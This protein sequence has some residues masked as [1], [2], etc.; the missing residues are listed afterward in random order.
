M[1]KLSILLTLVMSSILFYSCDKTIKGEGE[2]VQKVKNVDNFTQ[3]ISNIKDP[4]II[5]QGGDFKVILKGQENIIDNIRV[6]A[7]YGKLRIEYKDG[8]Q[9]SDYK[10]VEVMVN[11]PI[12]TN[13]SVENGSMNLLGK[14]QSNKLNFRVNG[15]GVILADEVNVDTLSAEVLSNGQLKI[16]QGNTV[17]ETI[18]TFGN[19]YVDLIGVVADTAIIKLSGSGDIYVNVLEYL[20]VNISGSG[21]VYYKGQPDIQQQIKGTGSLKSKE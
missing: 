5:T 17:K 2:I 9:F 10:P 12:L 16:N 7:Q 6:Y 11:L 15:V 4:I 1:K 14:F 19:S 20:D 18:S 21:D 3:V 8:A 13:A